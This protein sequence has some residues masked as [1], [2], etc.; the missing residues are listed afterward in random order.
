[1]R[2]R[3]DQLDGV[4]PLAEDRHQLVLELAEDL[5][6]LADL[7][8]QRLDESLVL[9]LDL[10]QR[11][12]RLV[13]ALLVFL[14][15]RLRQR[16]LLLFDALLE[17]G[18]SAGH[19]GL[20]LLGDLLQLLRLAGDERLDLGL[21]FRDFRLRFL[22]PL[23]DDGGD[24]HDQGI[25]LPLEHRAPLLVERVHFVGQ[26]LELVADPPGG[27]DDGNRE[28][29][30]DLVGAN[31]GIDEL[32]HGVQR[33]VDAAVE[34]AVDFRIER[35]EPR[36]DARLGC[37]VDRLD[38]VDDRFPLRFVCR[39]LLLL[40]RQDLCVGAAAHAHD[41]GGAH[42]GGGDGARG[43]GRQ[44]RLLGGAEFPGPGV[45]VLLDLVLG[46]YNRC[47]TRVVRLLH[48]RSRDLRL[49][50][51]FVGVLLRVLK[52]DVGV[53]LRG[54]HPFCGINLWRLRGAFL[55]EWL[56]GLRFAGWSRRLF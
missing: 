46:G 9:V 51:L 43:H 4:G 42:L 56:F 55:G 53:A 21:A 39:L 12:V 52:R 38:L 31:L 3:D 23:L 45:S 49:F 2:V 11:L 41:R 16:V 26:A 10:L 27:T 47:E 25:H 36:F 24:A 32:R 20:R 22:E 29:A 44:R 6:D 40:A 14:R 5:D 28:V 35:R 37:R 33:G 48:L 30:V 1:M 54:R 7:F 13:E 34:H 17:L 15:Q 18:E 8:R 19:V 50:H